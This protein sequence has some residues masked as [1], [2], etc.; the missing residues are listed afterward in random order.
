MLSTRKS[1]KPS[2]EV[3]EEKPAQAPRRAAPKRSATI[4]ETKT[5]IKFDLDGYVRGSDADTLVKSIMSAFKKFAESAQ[6]ALNKR[7]EM[8]AALEKRIEALEATQL[9]AR[10]RLEKR[11]HL[12]REHACQLS[13]RLMALPRKG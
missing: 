1:R 6:T 3:E 5:H 10:R 7:T 2:G 8:I 11:R 13:R 4:W 9:K 12:R